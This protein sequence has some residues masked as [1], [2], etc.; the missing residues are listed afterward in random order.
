MVLD[1]NIVPE[2][3]NE[4]TF[5]QIKQLCW[6]GLQIK[7]LAT[8]KEINRVQIPILTK[9]IWISLAKAMP[10]KRIKKGEIKVFITDPNVV[11]EVSQQGKMVQVTEQQWLTPK[12]KISA[13]KSSSKYTNKFEFPSTDQRSIQSTKRSEG[14]GTSTEHT[15]KEKAPTV[16]E[17]ETS[18]EEIDE[19]TTDEEAELLTQASGGDISRCTRREY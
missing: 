7:R 2:K 8:G 15:Q 19:D 9:K 5:H 14:E 6:R 13:H 17:A 12:K 3:R 11:Q 18:E 4:L 16:D 1:H 10:H